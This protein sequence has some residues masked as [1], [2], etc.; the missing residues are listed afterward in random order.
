[1]KTLELYVPRAT[2]HIIKAKSIQIYMEE[3]IKEYSE[4]HV[5]GTHCEAC[6]CQ[7]Y[8]T[9]GPIHWMIFNKKPDLR[10]IAHE[11]MHVVD[12]MCEAYNIYDTEFRAYLIGYLVEQITKK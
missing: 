1:M 12:R 3:F 10:T 11:S 9:Y 6:V 7:D 5:P 2:V 4:F 8:E